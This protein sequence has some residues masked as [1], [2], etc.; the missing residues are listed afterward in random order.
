MKKIR[1]FQSE[2]R[3]IVEISVE[4]NMM[5]VGANGAGKTRFGASLES[6]ND[7][8]KR[9]SS[10]RSL[11]LHEAVQKRD[12]ESAS[13]ELNRMYSRRPP[14]EPQNDYVQLLV[15]LF[16]EEA[17]RNE[18]AI[19]SVREGGEITNKNLPASKKEQVLE[20]WSLIFPYMSLSLSNDRVRAD[21]FSATEMSD[22]E[23]VGL[24]LIAQ[25]LLAAPGSTLI[26]DEP[27]LHLHKSLMVRLWNKLE[28][29]RSDCV[30]I[31]I[32]HDLDF[33]VNKFSNVLLWIEK[34]LGNMWKWRTVESIETVPDNLFLQILGSRKPVLFVE[35]LPGSLDIQFYQQYYENH[36]VIPRGSCEEVI[37]SVKALRANKNLHAHE[38]YG[39]IDRDF[40]PE[41]QLTALDQEGIFHIELNI[42]E[43]IFVLPEVLDLV[44]GHLGKTSAKE[45]IIKKIRGIY[46]A[47][48][49]DIKTA[50]FRSRAHRLIADKI[51]SVKSMAEYDVVKENLVNDL[52]SELKEINLPDGKMADMVEILK[53]YNKKNLMPLIQGELDLTREGYRDQVL[54]L[55][56][57]RKQEVVDAVKKYLPII[58]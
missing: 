22:G 34:F 36:T 5:I 29:Y 16:A 13:E 28:E 4:K 33:A 42:L 17:L 19:K 24:Y 21:G 53:V 20:V 10:Q 2:S 37:Q 18:S 9:I 25:V 51:T 52:D 35:G 30:F 27:E 11:V 47:A 43:N 40:R 3:E 12:Y 54:N 57:Q 38:V 56:M 1:V 44:C 15:S 55:L 49:D 8:V 26:I 14:T 46:I 39:L 32:T 31:Y 45:M 6:L 41:E 23:K 7:R 58:S 48:V 50:S